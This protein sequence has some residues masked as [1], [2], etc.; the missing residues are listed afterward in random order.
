MI[1]SI[2]ALNLLQP[3]T[4]PQTQANQSTLDT[5]MSDV[6]ILLGALSVFMIVVAG[7]RYIFARGNPEKTGQAKNIIMYSV[8]G[9]VIAG[10]AY[11]FVAFVLERAG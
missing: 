1:R 9:L 5:V 8:M 4:L 11:S 7:I 10:L 2:A 3:T 6:F